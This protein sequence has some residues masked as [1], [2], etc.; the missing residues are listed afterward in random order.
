MAKTLPAAETNKFKNPNQNMEFQ[1]TCVMKVLNYKTE[2]IN[3][4]CFTITRYICLPPGLFDTEN[5]ANQKILYTALMYN[6]F[7]LLMQ[8]NKLAG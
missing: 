5:C 1:H 2:G 7:W 8:C 4:L 6:S 3:G